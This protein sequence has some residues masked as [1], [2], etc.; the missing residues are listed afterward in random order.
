M[1]GLQTALSVIGALIV[2]AGVG[3]VL[4]AN[5]RASQ[6]EAVKKRLREERDDYLSRLNY[7]EPRHRALEQQNE[8]LLA[9]HNPKEQLDD[10]GVNVV[11]ALRLLRAQK[12]LME[13]ID[14]TLYL[15]RG[16]SDDRPS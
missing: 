11:E 2:L 8:V 7:I 3:G 13:Q 9:L 10:I 16:G 12:S 4:Y 1:N 5:F 15:P 14:R 6:D